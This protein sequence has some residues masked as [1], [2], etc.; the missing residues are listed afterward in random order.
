MP[1]DLL[2][3]ARIDGAN[4][5]QLFRHIT[6]PM[7]SP[8]I[9]FSLVVATIWAFQVFDLTYTMTKAALLGQHCQQACIFIIQPFKIII[10]VERQL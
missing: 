4:P 3:A 8:T 2:E 6:F 10:L 9:F 5:R 1:E 7:I